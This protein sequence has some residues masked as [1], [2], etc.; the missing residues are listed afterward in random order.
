MI[1]IQPIGT[2]LTQDENGFIV[3][4]LSINKLDKHWRDVAYYLAKAYKKELGKHVHS[5]Y[6]RGSVARGLVTEISGQAVDGVSD[7]DSF[8]LVKSSFSEKTIRWQKA[9]FQSFIE[10]EL[11]EKFPFAGDLEMMLA[12]YNRDFKNSRLAMIMKTQ[13]LLVDG[14]NIFSELKEYKAN[15]EMCLNYR[16]LKEDIDA[17]LKINPQSFTLNQCSE[18][19]KLIVR[20]G[21][22]LVIDKVGRF[23]PDLYICYRDFSKFYPTKEAE[24]RQTLHWYL[25]PILN[26]KELDKFVK[27]FGLWMERRIKQIKQI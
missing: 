2:Y 1:E 27:N 18:M 9:D 16:W 10:K 4:D 11:H 13:S 19:M 8:A 7:L 23:S 5:I 3:N 15:R 17:F 14:E 21:F 22:E 25:N 24:M 20:T 12:T 26:K 6:I